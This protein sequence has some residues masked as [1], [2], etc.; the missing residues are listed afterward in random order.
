LAQRPGR[1]INSLPGAKTVE[2]HY[3]HYQ[4]DW[5]REGRT[6][7][8]RSEI[9]VS[10]PVAVCRDEI[11]AKLAEAIAEIRAITAAQSRWSR[12]STNSAETVV[13]PMVDVLQSVP[14]V[15]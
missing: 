5:T 11:R 9:T 15:V 6:V 13:I 12:W 3:L 1:N 8:V 14:M 10:L 4:S 7:R 2:N